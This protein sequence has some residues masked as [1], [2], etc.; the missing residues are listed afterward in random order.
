M[1]AGFFKMNNF[2]GHRPPL[3]RV[4]TMILECGDLSLLSLTATG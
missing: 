1:T 3:Q 2:G 4:A